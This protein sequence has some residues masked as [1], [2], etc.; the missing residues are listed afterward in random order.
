MIKYVLKRLLMMI[1]VMLGVLTIAF[2]LNELTPGDAATAL[3][4]S[5]ATEEQV[6]AIREELGLN[7]PVLVRYGRY[8][9]GLFTRADMGTSYTTN[10]PVLDEILARY[11]TTLKLAFLSV[12]VAVL[13]GI[14]LGVIAAVKQYTWIDN[15]TMTISLLGVSMPP[16][17][18]GL[19]LVLLFSALPLLLVGSVAVR[20]GEPEGFI[21]LV[22]GFFI[23]G[24]EWIFNWFNKLEKL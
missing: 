3:A 6:E 7:A 1:P 17:W 18:L 19:L 21:L 24:A 14:P 8:V 10:Q 16:F 22:S 13:I 11:P 15:V 5:E 23:L 12:A 9:W 20:E 2:I 4:G